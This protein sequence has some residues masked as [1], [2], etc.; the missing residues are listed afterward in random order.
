[1]TDMPQNYKDNVILNL[2]SFLYNVN[3]QKITRYFVI[4]SK[5]TLFEF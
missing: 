4:L 2:I 5:D 1:M 3:Y